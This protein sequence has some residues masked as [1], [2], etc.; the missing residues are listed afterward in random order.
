MVDKYKE[1]REHYSKLYEAGSEL[2]SKEIYDSFHSWDNLLNFMPNSFFYGQRP[3]VW[4]TQRHD[5]DLLYG[6][7]K[8]G[9]A[10]YSAMRAD[11]QLSFYK[12]E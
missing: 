10:S 6:T 12:S 3:S 5:I 1:A 4:W 11:E 7:Y 8:Y 9:Y 2:T